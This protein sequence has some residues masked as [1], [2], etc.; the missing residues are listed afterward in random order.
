MFQN[1]H[2]SKLYFSYPL[3]LFYHF[4][5]YYFIFRTVLTQKPK[6]FIRKLHE[7]FLLLKNFVILNLNEIRFD[8]INIFVKIMKSTKLTSIT[9]IVQLFT[10]IV[11]DPMFYHLI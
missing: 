10:A 2:F 7:F 9:S 8:L 4:N 1:K 3:F 5:N 11:R 6:S